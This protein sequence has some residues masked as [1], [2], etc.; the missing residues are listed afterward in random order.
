MTLIV[1]VFAFFY[2][3][4]YRYMFVFDFLLHLLRMKRVHITL[5]H[6]LLHAHYFPF[7]LGYLMCYHDLPRIF[8]SCLP[9]PIWLICDLLTMSV[10]RRISGGPWSWGAQA[11]SFCPNSPDSFM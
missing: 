10:L 4:V 2:F 11:P 7:R 9:A 8:Q 3:L 5:L 1:C 6:A